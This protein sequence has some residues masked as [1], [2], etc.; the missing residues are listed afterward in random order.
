MSTLRREL[1][2]LALTTPW[3]VCAGLRAT[4]T[5]RGWP[6]VPALSFV[7][8]AAASS[9]LP[10]ALAAARRAPVATAVA[11][12]AAGVLAGATAGR[13]VAA[14]PPGP[15]PR[16]R[17]VSA[18]LLHGRADPA[19][20]VDLVA[21]FDADVLCLVELTPAADRGFRAAGLPDLL[22]SEHV[23]GHR[24]GAP[25]AAGGAVWTR[26]E[27]LERSAAPGRF[28]QPVVRL[29]VPGAPDLEVMAVH[30]DPPVTAR[31]TRRW[32]Q[33]MAQLPA[34]GGGVLRVL[35]GDFNATPDHA[36]YRRLL[37]RGYADAGA[38]TGRALVH[39]W[40]P[41]RRPQPRL[42]LDHVLADRRIGVASFQVH[43]LPGSDHRA[44]AAELVLPP[45]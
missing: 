10:L 27:V 9:V 5:E 35:A 39:T 45:V 22:P 2:P 7:P 32:E 30:T 13:T 31:R 23:R 16:V 38:R 34:A 44:L 36:T 6:L 3:A 29:A 18:N 1:L 41:E 24:P 19:V 21:S 4:G 42:T 43:D 33:E 11:A 37:A 12:A 40:T 28:E 17:V 26:L 25:P 14:P 8:Y 15:G 20:L